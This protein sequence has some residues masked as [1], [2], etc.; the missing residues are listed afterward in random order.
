MHVLE[1]GS[2]DKGHSGGACR[3]QYFSQMG[4]L[5]PLHHTHIH[6]APLQILSGAILPQ[7]MEIQSCD[8]AYTAVYKGQFPFYLHRHGNSPSVSHNC[9]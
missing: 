9:I 2:K 8:I 1:H 6:H 4:P 3:H 5:H 7:G